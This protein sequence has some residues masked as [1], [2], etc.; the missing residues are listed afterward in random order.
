MA[1][2]PPVL[3]PEAAQIQERLLSARKEQDSDE[4]EVKR[5]SA[6]LAQAADAAKPAIQDRLQLAQSQLELAQ[7][8]VQEANNDLLQAGGNVHQRIQMMQQEHDATERNAAATPA[9][10]AASPLGRL[11][12]LVGQVREWYAVRDKRHALEDAQRPGVVP[13]A[14]RKRR[15]K[16]RTLM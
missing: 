5:L 14:R 8:E 6:A 7:D 15:V 11:R 12:G 13:V 1:A 10:A 4:Q 9:A 2:H 3:S 16:V